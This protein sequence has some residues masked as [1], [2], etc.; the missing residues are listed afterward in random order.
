V[1]TGIGISR[2]IEGVILYRDYIFILFLGTDSYLRRKPASAGTYHEVTRAQRQD[3]SKNFH[4]TSFGET[5]LKYV[6]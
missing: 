5:E 6:E 3:K 2:L 4:K 1:A